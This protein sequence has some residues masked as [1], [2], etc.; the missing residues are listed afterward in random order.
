LGGIQVIKEGSLPDIND[1]MKITADYAIKASKERF[2]QE[3]D[4][5]EKSIAQLD[6]ILGFFQS[7]QG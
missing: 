3:L 7:I 2:K 5:S 4:F 6:I 1:E